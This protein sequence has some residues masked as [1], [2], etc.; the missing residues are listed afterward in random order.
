M[1]YRAQYD[2]EEVDPSPWETSLNDYFNNTGSSLIEHDTGRHD[3]EIQLADG[4][5]MRWDNVTFEKIDDKT[6]HY[7]A[8]DGVLIEYK[9]GGEIT[10]S[11]PAPAK[12]VKP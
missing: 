2:D 4:T 11:Q 3:V 9:W 1:S 8:P 5:V 10:V 6:A 7:H 12:M